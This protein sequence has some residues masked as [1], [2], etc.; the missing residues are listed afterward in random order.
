MSDGRIGQGRE[1]FTYMLEGYRLILWEVRGKARI[2]VA[3]RDYLTGMLNPIPQQTLDDADA[4]ARI[5]K[6]QELQEQRNGDVGM[7]IA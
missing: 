2:A 3:A 7:S 5:F 4:L 1:K 6:M